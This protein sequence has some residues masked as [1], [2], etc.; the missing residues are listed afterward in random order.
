MGRGHIQFWVVGVGGWGGPDQDGLDRKWVRWRNWNGGE[1][2]V[3]AE[4][5]WVRGGGVQGEGWGKEGGVGRGCGGCG[6]GV[7]MVEA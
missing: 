2:G 5:W 6:G 7:C 1:S 3:G 4:G